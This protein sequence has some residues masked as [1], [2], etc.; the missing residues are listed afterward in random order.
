MKLKQSLNL[1]AR[2]FFLDNVRDIHI[3]EIKEFLNHNE[4]KELLR[5]KKSELLSMHQQDSVLEKS[6]MAMSEL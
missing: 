4:R 1:K 6:F 3:L 5:S 2:G